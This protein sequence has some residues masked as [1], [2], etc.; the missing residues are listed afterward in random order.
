ML[1][2]VVPVVVSRKV[3]LPVG[4]PAPGLTTPTVAVNV[5]DWPNAAALRLDDKLV[6]V[7]DLATVW[8]RGV[9]VLAVKLVRSPYN[10][11]MV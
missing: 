2:R 9:V 3:T 5:T 6:V 7:F 1:P 11:V 10:T 8:N 4:V